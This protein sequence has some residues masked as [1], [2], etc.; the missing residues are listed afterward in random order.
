MSKDE[1][2]TDINKVLDQFS[3]E[4]LKGLL[5]FLKKLEDKHSDSIFNNKYLDKFLNEDKDFLDR[6]E[7]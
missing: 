5:I 4:T 7:K 6:L 3:D 2:K 1:I